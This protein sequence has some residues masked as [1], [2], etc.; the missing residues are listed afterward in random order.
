[1]NLIEMANQLYGRKKDEATRVNFLE[2][3][4]AQTGANYNRTSAISQGRNFQSVADRILELKNYNQRQFEVANAVD[5]NGAPAPQYN[6]T[7]RDA[8]FD[9]STAMLAA[10]N[11]RVGTDY[12][13]FDGAVDGFPDDNR[14]TFWHNEYLDLVARKDRGALLPEEEELLSEYQKFF[15]ARAGS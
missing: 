1:M 12:K 9:N 2:R 14:L 11:G 3:Q 4:A 8:Y 10:E 6:S 15:A 7:N 5:E 13:A